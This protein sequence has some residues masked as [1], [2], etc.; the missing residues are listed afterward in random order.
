MFSRERSHMKMLLAHVPGI[1]C[2]DSSPCVNW[3]CATAISG[4]FCP[5]HM[6]HSIQLV[7]LHGKRHGHKISSKLL[8]HNNY[9]FLRE[10]ISL[11]H[12]PGM[13]VQHFC[14]QAQAVI[15][16]L[17]LLPTMHPCYMSPQCAQHKFFVI[18]TCPCNIT[19]C[20]CPPL[21]SFT[22][23]GLKISLA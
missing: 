9:L 11:Q 6:L 15:L 17:Q 2:S 23:T 21:N 20:V 18:A 8:L 19:P 14:V 4:I 13:Y 1:C 10:D 3:Y 5:H 7:E 16:S 22:N 12:I